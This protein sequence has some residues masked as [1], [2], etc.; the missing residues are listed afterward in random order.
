M[1]TYLSK[2]MISSVIQMKPKD[3]TYKLHDTMY[4]QLI[5]KIE[6][7]CNDIGYVMKDSL[8]IVNKS[9]GTIVNINNINTVSYKIGY[10][11][12]IIQ[13]S[14][15]ETLLCTIDNITNAGVIAYVKFKDIIPN[16]EKNNDIKE[17][18][19]IC[20]IPLTRFQD[21][22][23]LTRQQKLKVKITAV[24]NKLNQKNIQIVG[25]PV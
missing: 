11:C 20:I 14:I 9:Y 13:P 12:D 3:I 22:D 4:D 24:R 15:G 25:N 19:I 21:I 8:K 10:I 23:N 16:Y 2:Q 6:G 7:K 18:P 5:K 17:S 1:V